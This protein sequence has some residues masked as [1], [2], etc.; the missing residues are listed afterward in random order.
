MQEMIRSTP[1]DR[2]PDRQR[3]VDRFE[4]GELTSSERVAAQ[5]VDLVLADPPPDEVILRLA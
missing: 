4:A 5:L 1:A 3:F 2:F